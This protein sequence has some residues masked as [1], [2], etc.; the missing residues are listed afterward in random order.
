MNHNAAVPGDAVVAV[1]TR[2]LS[3]GIGTRSTN[4]P[5]KTTQSNLGPTSTIY[6][7]RSDV[8]GPIDYHP[9]HHLHQQQQLRFKSA[10]LDHQDHHDEFP[11]VSAFD[12]DFVSR[13]VDVNRKAHDSITRH[14]EEVFH[15]HVHDKEA[16]GRLQILDVASGPGEPA[17]SLAKA[18][19]EAS[20]HS[21][22]ISSDMV[23]A[24]ESRLRGQGNAQA[25][26]ADME[27]LEDFDDGTFDLVTCSYGLMFAEDPDQALYEIHRVLKPGGTL[28]TTV[29]ENLTTERAADTLLRAACDG[30]SVLPERII[31]PVA[32]AGPRHL[33]GLIEKAGMSLITVDQG[34]Y[35]FELKGSGNSDDT[36]KFVSMPVYPNLV[37]LVESGEYPQAM[38]KAKAAF[39]ETVANEDWLTID[40]DGG[41]KTKPNRY[42]LAVARRKYEDNDGKRKIVRRKKPKVELYQRSKQ[43]PVHTS[44]K[45][46][47][48]AFDQVLTDAYTRINNGPWHETVR[49]VEHIL[50]GHDESRA[51]IL[52]LGSG[53]NEPAASLIDRFPRASVTESDTLQKLSAFE[54]GSFDVVTCAFGLSFL[55]DPEKAMKEI[56]RV[57]KPGGSLVMAVW[58]SLSVDHMSDEIMAAVMKGNPLPPRAVDYLSLARP[59]AVAK[60]IEGSNMSVIKID[61]EEFPFQLSGLDHQ[62]DDFAFNVATIPIHQNLLDLEKSGENPNAFRD[63]HDAFKKIIDDGILVHKDSKGHLFTGPNR[64][65]LAIARRQFEDADG[66]LEK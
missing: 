58:D 8:M 42:K 45:E 4:M 28:I 2:S 22:D 50:R 26:V 53:V 63:A 24:A 32:L 18:F 12:A 20:V 16:G 5:A 6:K 41:I 17:A 36:F 1:S 38:E 59:H 21:T 35:S 3:H 49:K 60:L 10:M 33:E 47:S 48:Q 15:G 55:D 61:H 19:P 44:P 64:F 13:I 11:M 30:N 56:H 14:A 40:D 29:W 66:V 43:P 57:L 9:Q 54:D 65:K 7:F 62:T 39:Y 27:D 34:E 52:N 46:M 37:D 25:K 31:D 23:K 51:K